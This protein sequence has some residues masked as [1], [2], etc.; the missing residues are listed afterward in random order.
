MGSRFVT[1]WLLVLA[2][3]TGV[4]VG[5]GLLLCGA[6]PL[7]LRAGHAAAVGDHVRPRQVPVDDG[8][9]REVAGE[10]QLLEEPL[11][12][13]QRREAAL[14]GFCRPSVARAWTPLP[15]KLRRLGRRA[16][17]ASVSEDGDFTIR[18]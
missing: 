9:V 4:D 5:D 13:A 11:D 2:Q 6:Q 8:R 18:T 15:R 12:V 7:G 14:A 17:R 10:R 1:G 16:C 3:R